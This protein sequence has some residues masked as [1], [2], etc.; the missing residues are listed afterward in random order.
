MPIYEYVCTRCEKEFEKLL[1]R[2]DDPVECPACGAP[3]VK[4]RLSSFSVAR[5]SPSAPCG[6]FPSG[7]CASCPGGAGMCGLG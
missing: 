3:E 4:R 7:G 2:S 1:W 6:E 5:K